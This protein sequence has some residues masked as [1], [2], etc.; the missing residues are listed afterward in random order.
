MRGRI[1][2]LIIEELFSEAMPATAMIN[3]GHTT[4]RPA[5][6]TCLSCGAPVLNREGKFALKYIRVDGRSVRQ[7]KKRLV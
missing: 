1:S 2:G 3:C 7:E 5:P 6:L 4:L